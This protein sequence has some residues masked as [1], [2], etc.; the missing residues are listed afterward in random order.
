M[1]NTYESR[2]FSFE[3][4]IWLTLDSLLF[5]FLKN[6]ELDVTESWSS[7]GCDSYKSNADFLCAKDGKE[8][9]TCNYC[10][11]DERKDQNNQYN[12][13][14]NDFWNPQVLLFPF[15]TSPNDLN[16]INNLSYNLDL[17]RRGLKGRDKNEHH[18]KHRQATT[19]TITFFRNDTAVCI[20]DNGNLGSFWTAKH[21]S[22][23][24]CLLLSS[25]HLRKKLGAAPLRAPM[26]LSL[27]FNFQ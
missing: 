12:P 7:Q 23:H 20:W 3:K 17:F 11:R 18:R 25:L 26:S 9:K 16:S 6:T 19:T 1:S 10:R 4:A 13:D 22:N 14:N 27:S 24:H 8:M 2:D 15:P 5:F 21:Y